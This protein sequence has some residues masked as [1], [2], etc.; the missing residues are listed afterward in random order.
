MCLPTVSV[1]NACSLWPKVSNF[2]DHFKENDI[3]LSLITE[4]WG[5][6]SKFKKNKIKELLEMKGIDFIYDTRKDKC[7]GGTAIAV[8]ANLF[9]ISRFNL[10]IP[11]GLELTVALIRSKSVNLMSRPII[12]FSIYSSPRSKYKE[13]LLNFLRRQISKIKS[14]FLS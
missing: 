1:I 13:D 6:G 2:V 11:I 9:S 4:V 7:G 3:Q 12:A 14:N 5:K 8:C 10:K